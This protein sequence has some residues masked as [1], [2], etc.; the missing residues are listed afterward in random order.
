MENYSVIIPSYTVGP[1]AYDKIPEFCSLYGN[2]AV[3][4]GGQKAM[5]AAGGK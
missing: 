1:E 4:I 3:V 2:K 5:A